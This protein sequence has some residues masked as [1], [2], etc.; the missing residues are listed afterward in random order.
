MS[1]N[2]DATTAQTPVS[3]ATIEA[4]GERHSV[5]EGDVRALLDQIATDIHEHELRADFDEY[6][7]LKGTKD[8]VRVYLCEHG[9]EVAE[10]ADHAADELDGREFPEHS[11][12][13]T[14]ATMAFD[15]EA[16]ERYADVFGGRDEV[17]GATGV[18]DALLVADE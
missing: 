17:V 13:S 5:S 15:Y 14:V 3:D 9:L 18:A 16:R 6:H 10:L 7:D 4:V 1:R 2:T 8:G 12:P 11:G